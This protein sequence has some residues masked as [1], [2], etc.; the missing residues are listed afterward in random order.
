MVLFFGYI[1]EKIENY[2]N[3]IKV[4]DFRSYHR[5]NEDDSSGEKETKTSGAIDQILNL[6]FQAYG[7]LVTKIGDYKDAAN[8]LTGIAKE[9]DPAKKGQ[10]MLNVLTKVAGK[11][12]PKYKEAADQLV[13]AA[14]RIKEAYDSAIQTDEGKKA[15]D[16]IKD[17]IYD[18]IIGF[19]DSLKA[20]AKNAPKIENKKEE[21]KKDAESDDDD[22]SNYN[23]E[24]TGDKKTNES[25][26]EEGHLYLFE[27]N[28]FTDDREE[29]IKDITP[30]ITLA[31]DLSKNPASP[32]LGAKYKSI[33]SSLE[34]L[35]SELSQGNEE[36]WKKMKRRERKER[37]AAIQDE[38]KKYKEELVTVSMNA[39]KNLGIDKNVFSK[40]SQAMELIKGSIDLMDKVDKEEMEKSKKEEEDAEAK[41]KDEE[42]AEEEDKDTETFDEIKSGT[43]DVKNLQKKGPNLDK[44][45]AAQEK[46]NAL[47]PEKEKIKADGLYG[48]NTEKAIVKVANMFKSLAPDLLDKTDGKSLT[49]EFQQFLSK[50]EKNKD[51]IADLFKSTPSEPAKAE[52]VKNFKEHKADTLPN[53]TVVSKKKK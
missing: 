53:V 36:A 15:L 8:D 35:Q 32:D 19:L 21:S 22:E 14:K 13:V 28:T 2:M 18:R 38:V 12:D 6:F 16:Q 30:Q 45:K 47:L 20:V 34:K 24:T 27:K 40:I 41:K 44:I 50:I 7:G 26:V 43:S 25:W 1:N 29:I 17:D 52:K 5:I 33:A 49:P 42:A 46:I 10:A 4:L 37:I 51:K 39:V 31:K 11:V 9:A 3:P 48:T 23:E